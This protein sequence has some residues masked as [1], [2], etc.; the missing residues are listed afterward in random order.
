MKTVWVLERVLR[1]EWVS[2]PFC[3]HATSEA[4]ARRKLEPYLIHKDRPWRVRDLGPRSAKTIATFTLR[5]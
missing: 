1:G 5:F 4:E 2:L 3:T